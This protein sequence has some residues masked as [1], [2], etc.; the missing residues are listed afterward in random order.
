MQSITV[1][2]CYIM[3]VCSIQSFTCCSVF[4]IV[5]HGFFYTY[6]NYFFISLFFISFSCIHFFI[7]QYYN[8][9]FCK[10]VGVFFH[11]VFMGKKKILCHIHCSYTLFETY[12]LERKFLSTL[13][14]FFKLWNPFR[15]LIIN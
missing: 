12:P 1:K 6:I 9:I 7:L 3:I 5:L 13:A 10:I 11:I 14:D 8:N 4:A 15:F 2:A